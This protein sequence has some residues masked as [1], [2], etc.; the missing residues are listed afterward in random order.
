M[1][2]FIIK[3]QPIIALVT[4]LALSAG[5]ITPV[6]AQNVPAP[7]PSPSASPP[8]PTTFN[9]PFNGQR[10]LNGE[11]GKDFTNL[12]SLYDTMLNADAALKRRQDV[13]RQSRRGPSCVRRRLRRL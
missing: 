7:S 13:R 4:A 10:Q 9:S 1:R 3:H 5:S 8:A 6:Y 12:M 11:E 2:K